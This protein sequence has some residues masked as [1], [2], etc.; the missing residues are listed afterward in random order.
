MGL[1]YQ[2]TAVF[3]D[4]VCVKGKDKCLVPDGTE[5]VVLDICR[6]DLLR[7]SLGLLAVRSAHLDQT[8]G[9]AARHRTVCVHG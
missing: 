6:T 5:G 3:G 4:V 7:G 8:V 1:Q 2:Y 9:V